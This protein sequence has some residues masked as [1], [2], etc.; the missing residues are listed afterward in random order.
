[1]RFEQPVRKSRGVPVV[2]MIDLLFV[3]LIFLVVSTTFKKPRSVLPIELPTLKEITGSEVVDS[4]SVLSLDKEGKITLDA[5]AV[6]DVLLL[7][8]YLKAFTKENP[9][10]KL[11]LEADKQVPLEKLLGVWDA[12]TRAGI[13][14]KDV[15]ARIRLPQDAESPSQ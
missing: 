7:D 11:E 1:M 5:V 15:P 8:S 4:R 9:G 12:L 6:P 2:P 3:I 10:R 13:A 14:I